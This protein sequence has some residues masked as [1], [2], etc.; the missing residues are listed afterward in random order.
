V[1]IQLSNVT[2]TNVALEWHTYMDPAGG[3]VMELI[4]DGERLAVATVNMAPQGHVPQEDCVFIKD[5]SEN[6]GILDSLVKAGVI[7]D[8]GR[9]VRAG[10]VQVQEVQVL[11]QYAIDMKNAV[12]QGRRDR[13]KM[14]KELK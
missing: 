14:L 12:N 7:R 6:S 9:A 8:T 4:A 5:Y 2:Y 1:R 10:W 13:I 11:G 3:A